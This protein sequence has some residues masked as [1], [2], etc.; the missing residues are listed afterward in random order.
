MKQRANRVSSCQAALRSGAVALI[1][2][3]FAA[4][5]ADEHTSRTGSIRI[6]HA[7]LRAGMAGQP[8]IVFADLLNGG[9]SDRLVKV[10]VSGSGVSR[11]I[12]IRFNNGKQAEESLPD[13][14]LP[15]NR[16]TNLSPTTAAI[17]IDG[18]DR[19]FRKGDKLSLLF[20]FANAPTVTVIAKSMAANATRH[21]HAG[22]RH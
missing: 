7:W 9:S 17:R 8:V 18:I 20:I 22:H 14:E 11:F 6:E 1:M 16:V 2:V 12:G 19:A 21:D 4:Q 5:A 15:A 13:I 3:S 10:E